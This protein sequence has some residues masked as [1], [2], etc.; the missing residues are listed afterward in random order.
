MKTIFAAVFL[1]FSSAVFAQKAEWKEMHNFHGIMSVT[2][3]PSEENNLQPLRDSVAVLV[4]KAKAWQSSTVP[5]GYNAAATAPILKK[6][7]KQC[8]ELQRAVA[9][10]KPDEALKKQIA[11]AHDTFHEIMEKCGSNE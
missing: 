7:V 4:T 5:Q 10:N 6:L 11:A 3:H 8:Q 2:F 1:L 9:A